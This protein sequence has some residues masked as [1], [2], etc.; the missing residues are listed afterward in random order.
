MSAKYYKI[1]AATIAKIQDKEVRA[2]VAEMFC[3]SLSC[4][5]GHFK[6]SMFLEACGL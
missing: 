4:D 6:R 5:N 2:Y 3:A 1:I